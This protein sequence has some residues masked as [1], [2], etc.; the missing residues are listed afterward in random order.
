MDRDAERL[1]AKVP[2]SFIVMCEQS[3]LLHNGPHIKC[4]V[5]LTRS[6]RLSNPNRARNLNIVAKIDGYR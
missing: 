5:P 4:C 2:K 6:S 1:K 3:K